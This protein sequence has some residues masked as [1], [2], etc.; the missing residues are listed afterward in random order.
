MMSNPWKLRIRLLIAMSLLFGLV[1]AIVLLTM[2]LLGFSG[3]F[4]IFVILG[5]GIIFLQYLLGPTIVQKT[6]GVRYVTEEK[7]PELHRMV[8]DLAM[9]AGIPKPKIGISETNVPN[10]FA[11][12][13]TKNDGRICVTRGILNTLNKEELK[14]VLG[15]ELAHIKHN[16][17]AVTTL[18][19]AIPLICYYI[20]LSFIFGGDNKNNGGIIIGI[21][22]FGAY[23]IGQLLVLFISRTR[24]YYA[25]HGSIE[26]GGRPDKLTSALY[27]LVYGASKA[28]K[29]EIKEIEGTK[30]FFLNDVTNAR[31]DIQELSQLDVDQDG[32]I[33][34]SDLAQLK[35]KKVNIKT[36]EKVAELFS[37]H[38]NML[39][40]IEKI[41][42]YS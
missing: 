11:F 2:S 13:R 14:A 17:M 21:L 16:D 15:H 3:N 30:A 31:N 27:K 37:T 4:T 5:L 18:V 1:Y 22:A 9:V 25:D 28:S 24:E 26:I 19:S 34:A 8:N 23:I 39:K 6:M 32:E 36:S 29:E 12:G 42:E 33:S 41:A 10:A 7:V 40:R 38:P 35:Y 20:S